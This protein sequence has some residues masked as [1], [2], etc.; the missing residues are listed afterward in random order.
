M[1]LFFKKYFWTVNLVFLAVASFLTAKTINT[2]VGARF[3]SMPEVVSEPPAAPEAVVR[4]GAKDVSAVVQRNIFNAEAKP[5]VEQPPAAP[6]PQAAD[7]VAEGGAVEETDLD[8]ELVGVILTDHPLWSFAQIR[9]RRAEDSQLFK[10]GDTIRGEA[11]IIA[12][13]WRRLLLLRNGRR[14]TLTLFYDKPK[15]VGTA[16]PAVST[17]TGGPPS[18]AV[19]DRNIKKVGEDQYIIA[20]EEVDKQL[21]NLNYLATQARIVPHF[22]G[23]RG[24][25]FKLFAIRPGSLY[26]KIGIQNGDVV[27]RINGETIDSPDKALEAYARLKNAR[28]ITIDLVRGGVKKTLT[29]SIGN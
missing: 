10:I 12:I 16:A 17:P 14:E 5:E 8:V 18:V 27:K 2:F 11:K 22:E 23:G 4:R 26:S 15:R 21:S 20:R 29:Y 6:Q 19:D 9:E 1:E 25:G 13:E 3:Q 28:Q 7:A 24:A